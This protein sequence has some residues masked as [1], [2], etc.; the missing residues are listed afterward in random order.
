MITPS[1]AGW[2]QVT[3]FSLR[4]NTQFTAEPGAIFDLTGADYARE[5]S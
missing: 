1:F 2:A 5:Y 4:H 3:P